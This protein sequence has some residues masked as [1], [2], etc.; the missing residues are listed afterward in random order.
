MAQSEFVGSSMRD[1]FEQAKKILGEDAYIIRSEQT[2]KGVKIFAQKST[3][4]PCLIPVHID[5]KIESDT[6]RYYKPILRQDIQRLQKKEVLDF[7]IKLDPITLIKNVVRICEKHGLGGDFCDAWIDLVSKQFYTGEDLLKETLSELI[8]FN[9]EWVYKLQST[10]P[11]IFVG[12]QGSGKTAFIGKLAVVLK[13]L[14]RDLRIITLDQKAGAFH[15]LKTYM[16]MLEVH[17]E[18]GIEKY[19]IEKDAAI[20]N[21]QILLVDTP[22]INILEQEGQEYLFK[23]SEQITTPLTLVLPNDMSE[24]LRCEIAAEFVEYNA[25]YLIG[26]RFDITKNYGTFFHCAYK[27]KLTPVLYSDTPAISVAPKILSTESALA[28]LEE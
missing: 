19:L 20:K 4:E 13:S 16:D 3:D 23:L 14:G 12:P 22:G 25:Q 15:Q 10:I 8:T 27:N 11:V 5:A 26:T 17:T 6:K 24:N 1:A 2:E 18:Q 7:D 9:T 21:N 28:L